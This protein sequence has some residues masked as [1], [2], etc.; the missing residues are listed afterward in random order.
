[1]LHN[2]AKIL[3]MTRFI[4]ADT[5]SSYH[6]IKSFHPNGNLA[7]LFLKVFRVKTRLVIDS[8]KHPVSN[9]MILIAVRNYYSIE[10]RINWGV[11]G[12]LKKYF[13]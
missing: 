4:S 12:I 8:L 1:M 5:V 9:S 7:D 10:N 2:K 13:W 3:D 11:N 6:H